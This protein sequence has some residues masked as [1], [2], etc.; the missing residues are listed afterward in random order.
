MWERIK[1][2]NNYTKALEQIDKELIHWPNFTIHKCKQ[3]VTKI[4]QYLIKMRRLALRQQPKLV[5]I[6]KKLDRRE[7]VRERKALSAAKL[8]RSIEAELIER[9]KS[10]AYGDA[11]LN[12]NEA[13]WQAVLDREKGEKGKGKEL[14]LEDDETDEEDEED[15][16]EEEEDEGWGEREFVSD[17]SGDEDGLSDLEDAL[18]SGEDGEDEEDEDKESDEDEPSGKKSTL[19]KRKAPSRTGKPPKKGPE[20]KARRGPRVEVEYEHEM[21]S[22]PLTKEALTNW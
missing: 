20:K 14:E 10:K 3:R 7:A 21:E 18:S 9:L 6:K 12:V 13:V 4:T 1:L 17:V 15:M 11:P 5:G 22:V 16:E 2:S 8:E 19:G